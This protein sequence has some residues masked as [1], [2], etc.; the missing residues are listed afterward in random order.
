M[1]GRRGQHRRDEP[2]QRGRVRRDRGL[3]AQVLAE[4]HDR[5]TVVADRAAQDHDVA[6]SRPVAGHVDAGRHDADAGGRDEHAVALALLDDL[7]V[8]GHHRDLRVLR[9]GGHRFDDAPQIG[10]REALLEHEGRREVERRRAAHRDVVDRA[11]HRQAADVA[12]RKEQ[13]RDDVAVGRHHEP[14]RRHVDARAIV[15]LAQPVVVERAQEQ[16]VDE[17]RHRAAA[18]AVRH[19]DAA[20][21]EVHR[22]DVGPGHAVAGSCGRSPTI[23]AS[24]KR[25]YV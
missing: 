23:A 17:L 18:A 15:A 4:R 20:V 19:V 14:A 7:G 24:L 11:V 9:G 16:L 3:E 13:R 25:P 12:A 8:T 21:T 5:D 2:V 10:E 22:T 1:P 6:G